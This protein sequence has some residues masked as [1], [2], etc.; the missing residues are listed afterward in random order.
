MKDQEAVRFKYYKTIL[1]EAPTIRDAVLTA[2]EED[3]D[4]PVDS[5]LYLMVFAPALVGFADWVLRK[6]EMEKKDRIYFLSRD[7]YQIYLTAKALAAKRRF[8]I[9]C[10]YFHISRYAARIPTYYRNVEES[11]DT[12]C[13][14]G[15]DVT[16]FKILKKGALTDAECMEILDELNL[17]GEKDKILNYSEVL[18]LKDRLKTS[19]KIRTYIESHSKEAYEGAAAFFRQEGLTDDG[20]YLIVD[21]GWIGTLQQSIEILV[22]SMNPDI[23]VQ[24][25]YFGMYDTPKGMGEDQFFTYF[26]SKRSGLKRKIHFSNSLFE[27]I[28][29]SEEGMTIGYEKKE[30]H[31]KPVF[32]ENA[33]PNGLQM[34]QNLMAL[35]LFLKHLKTDQETLIGL[36][37][38]EKL[39]Y[40]FMSEPSLLEV[41]AYGDNRFSDDVM[42]G[43]LKKVAAE[44]SEEQIRNQRFFR[45]L[46][47]IAGIRKATIYESAWL[48]GST[49]RLYEKQ[50]GLARKEYRH[51]R[52]YKAFVFGKKQFSRK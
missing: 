50:P 2:I 47:I 38:I 33:N 17:C 16:P 1:E 30:D 13:T 49:A 45:K 27:T 3:P 42:E 8:A 44:L 9:S 6:A 28:V 29:S 22:Q 36:P 10:K 26:F 21:S 34:E 15:I 19:R 39:F 20:N 43:T 24:G 5:K 37:V 35:Q 40:R 23:R 11:F 14:G 46:L 41:K 18:Q 4:M 51:I 48:E 25:C 7:G 31:Y 52:L 32:C 12:I